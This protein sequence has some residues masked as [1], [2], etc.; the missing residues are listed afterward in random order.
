M[1]AGGHRLQ[2]Q[3]LVLPAVLG[4]LCSQVLR[5]PAQGAEAADLLPLATGT[6]HRSRSAGVVTPS[7]RTRCAQPAVRCSGTML[8][9]SILPS[10]QPRQRCHAPPGRT[11]FQPVCG[12]A[13]WLDRHLN[14]CCMGVASQSGRIRR[15]GRC[16]VQSWQ[17]CASQSDPRLDFMGTSMVS[18][19]CPA[20]GAMCTRQEVRISR[21]TAARQPLPPASP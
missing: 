9:P 5:L 14:H 21:S 6:P 16:V 3:L 11:D 4:P 1:P 10:T 7:Q 8:R 17:R 13:A 20:R 15:S 18:E 2:Q 19:C 12:T